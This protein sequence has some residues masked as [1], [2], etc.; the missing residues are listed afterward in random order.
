MHLWLD[1]PRAENQVIVNHLVNSEQVDMILGDFN[2]EFT[3]LEIPEGWSSAGESASVAA[4][5]WLLG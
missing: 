4:C 5:L 3:D 2:T 1:H